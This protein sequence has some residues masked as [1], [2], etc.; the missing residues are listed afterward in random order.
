MFGNQTLQSYPEKKRSILIHTVQE[1]IRHILP[2]RLQH[3]D[4]LKNISSVVV[5]RYGGKMI[6]LWLKGK[7]RVWIDRE[8]AWISTSLFPSEICGGTLLQ[9]E[10]FQHETSWYIGW[11][12]ILVK[13]NFSLIPTTGYLERLKILQ[14]IVRTIGFQTHSEMDPGIMIMKPIINPSQIH[15]LFDSEIFILEPKIL[16]FYNTHP[17]PRSFLSPLSYKINTFHSHSQIKSELAIKQPVYHIYR[18][19]E[20]KEPDQFDLIDPFTKLP[21]G[22]ACIRTMRLSLWLRDIPN[23]SLVV[24]RRFQDRW[25]PFAPASPHVVSRIQS[26]SKSKSKI[27]TLDSISDM[28]GTCLID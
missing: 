16:L 25:E 21:I 13:D 17:K 7:T 12:D 20:T 18:K 23:G 10:I 8:T 26:K 5:P 6:F 4:A 9:A 14:L 2:R 22:D 24:C 28:K 11:E 15:T 27:N 1:T 19:L 3:G